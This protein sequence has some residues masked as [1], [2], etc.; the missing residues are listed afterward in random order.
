MRLIMPC[1]SPAGESYDL[2]V[3]WSKRLANELPLLRSLFSEIQAKNILEVAC[4][5]G[6][7][8]LQLTKEG[9]DVT[10]LDIDPGLIE[11]AR[12][13]A[14]KQGLNINFVVADFLAPGLH[15]KEE[16]DAIFA[17]GNSVPLISKES[18]YEEVFKRMA[19]LLRPGGVVLVHILNFEKE[20]N[21]WTKPRTIRTD[22]MEHFFV[23]RFETGSQELQIEILHLYRRISEPGE[24]HLESECANLRRITKMEVDG[25]LQRA[26]FGGTRFMANYQG[27]PFSQSSQDLIII[28]RKT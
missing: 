7:H 19:S 10:G 18:S 22:S 23:R 26:G 1:P 27:E 6:W 12:E 16:F 21:E 14:S 3:D 17:L 24:W 11:V 5:S 28:A 8:S 4:S 20:R 15:F 13:R 25:A 2:L 9:Y